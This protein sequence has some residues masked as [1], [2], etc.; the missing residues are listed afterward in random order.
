MTDKPYKVEVQADDTGTWAGNGLRF[1]TRGEAGVCG[2]DLACRWTAVREWRVV[3][4]E[5]S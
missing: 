5:A 3:K 4:E 1:E 2:Q